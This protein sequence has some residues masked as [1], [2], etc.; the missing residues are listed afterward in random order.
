MPGGKRK[1]TFGARP[2]WSLRRRL[3]EGGKAALPP[4]F[5]ASGW[6]VARI[7]ATVWWADFAAIRA[8]YAECERITAA[9]GV[10]HHVDHIVPLNHPRVCGLHVHFNLRCIPACANMSKGN[11][12]CPEQME[13]FDAPE[14]L[15]LL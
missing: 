10:E 9:T 12:W 5:A 1:G 8:V 14:Q 6:I 4:S 7:R 11:D 3:M 13:L 2:C 15:R